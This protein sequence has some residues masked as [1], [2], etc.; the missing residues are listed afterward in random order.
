MRFD[1]GGPVFD[2]GVYVGRFNPIHKGHQRTID[3]MLQNHTLNHSLVMVGSANAPLS[4]RNLFT[5]RERRDFI[6]VLYPELKI[7]PIA[8]QDSDDDWYQS[9]MDI[10]EVAFPFYFNIHL[11]C[12]DIRDL[13]KFNHNNKI[14]VE[15]VDRYE[16]QVYSATSVREMIM[17]SEC[18][19]LSFILDDKIRINTYILG[20]K[21]L[22][23]LLKGEK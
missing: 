10:V 20:R 2:V 12:G 17:E 5:Y 23:E 9:M 14:Q 3:A 8:D 1:L 21:R 6:K 19:A 18:E 16:E 22:K 13:N 11:Y 4:L 15:V 7:V